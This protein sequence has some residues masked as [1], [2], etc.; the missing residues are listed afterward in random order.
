MSGT[1]ETS[2]PA[3]ETRWFVSKCRGRR[4]RG[5]DQWRRTGCRKGRKYCG[6]TL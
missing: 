1:L 4:V 3:P 5:R 6:R 2:N